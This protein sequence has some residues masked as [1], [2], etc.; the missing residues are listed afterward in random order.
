MTTVRF[1]TWNLNWF[2]RSPAW[3]ES[4]LE[5]LYGQPWDVVA[6]QEVTASMYSLVLK[7]GIAEHVAYSADVAAD[8]GFGSAL[9][10]RNGA[11][12]EHPC[13]MAGL[14]NP[15][16]G[17]I[18]R[19]TLGDVAFTAASWHAPNAAKAENR[20]VKAAAYLSFNHLV[21]ERRDPLVIGADANHGA[22]WTRTLDFPG[23][24]FQPIKEDDW[25]D[26][27]RFW[28]Q[29]DHDLR[30]MWFEFLAA[31]PDLVA[32][33]RAERPEGPSAISYIRGSPKNPIPDRFDYI[34]ASPEFSVTNM[35]YE[36]ERAKVAG[37]DHAFVASS[38]QLGA[39]DH[40][41]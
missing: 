22:R 8:R 1:A 11:A 14:P 25:L 31:R 3:A 27:N 41:R 15:N 33:L 40:A 19:V 9:L 28:A 32:A 35:T 34:L 38:L 2:K 24:P 17:V 4:K 20:A 39:P 18:A 5:F 7:S 13:L 36:Y 21:R 16:W 29:P 26:E 10:A 23:E 12:L 30:D 37:S 6:L